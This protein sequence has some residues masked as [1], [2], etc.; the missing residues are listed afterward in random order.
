MRFW[1]VRLPTMVPLMRATYL[2]IWNSPG[3]RAEVRCC[4]NV[5]VTECHHVK[6]FVSCESKKD[7]IMA[8]MK[9]ISYIAAEEARLRAQVDAEIV[10]AVATT[11]DVVEQ[12]TDELD[13]RITVL[14]AKCLEPC[15]DDTPRSG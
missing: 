10:G 9:I 2:V 11:L 3:G 7:S 4:Q 15:S 12:E 13:R 1:V 5:I 14:E 8:G 6:R